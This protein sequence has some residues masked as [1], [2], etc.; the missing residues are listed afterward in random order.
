[1]NA[2]KPTASGDRTHYSY[3]HYADPAV[4]DGFDA[5]RFSGPIGR[6][7]LESQEA[8]LMEMLAPL[9]A[10]TILDVGTG[11]G[12]AALGLAAAGA[13]VVGLDA[14]AEMLRVARRRA[15]DAGLPPVFG[16]ADAQ[17]LPLASGAVDAAVCLRLLMHVIDWRRAVAELCRVSRWR[18][19]V[20]F[21]A[22]MSF[23]AL[24]SR[25]RKIGAAAGRRTEPYRVMAERDVM[26]AFTA[27]GFRVVHTSRQFVLP[28]AFHKKIGRLGFTEASERALAAV[29]LR[30]L[31]GSP[32]TMVAER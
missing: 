12:R 30:R 24:E 28:I 29:G 16:V 31:L 23:A 22:A 4:A 13:H 21:P 32:V 10:R 20:D 5:L 6:Y 25:A 3:Q 7:L 15:T 11:T 19:I 9:E 2:P 1:M 26:N 8:L 27:H 18:V 14:S 17:H